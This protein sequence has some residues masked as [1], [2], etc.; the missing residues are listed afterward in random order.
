MGKTITFESICLTPTPQLAESAHWGNAYTKN[1]GVFGKIKNGVFCLFFRAN[2]TVLGVLVG[3]F[4]LLPSDGH[5]LA[6]KKKTGNL[7][8]KVPQIVHFSAGRIF[9]KLYGEQ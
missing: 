7:G 6:S 5:K 4:C 2:L 8:P 3:G 9:K 1:T